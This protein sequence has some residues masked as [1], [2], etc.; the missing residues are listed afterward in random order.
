MRLWFDLYKHGFKPRFWCWASQVDSTS[1]NS[2]IRNANNMS[3]EGTCSQSLDVEPQRNPY[4]S[5]VFDAIRPEIMSQ[6]EQHME[7]PL[8]KEAKKFMI[9]C[10]LH[11]NHYGKVV[12]PTQNYLW[13]LEC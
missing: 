5:M 12:L 3:E 8:N 6:F 13:Q 7:E 10:T 2:N 9:C 11:N 4:E 1:L